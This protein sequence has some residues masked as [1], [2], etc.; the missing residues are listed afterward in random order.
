MCSRREPANEPEIKNASLISHRARP[1]RIDCGRHQRASIRHQ[2]QSQPVVDNVGCVEETAGEPDEAKSAAGN[3]DK[4][5][6][7]GNSGEESAVDSRKSESVG[8]SN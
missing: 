6:F 7:V 2:Q 3:A 5:K 1:G 8:S 4:S